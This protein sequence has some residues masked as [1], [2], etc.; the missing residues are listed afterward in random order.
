MATATLKTLNRYTIAGHTF[1][2]GVAKT[3]P[4]DLA[5]RLSEHP[6][7]SERLAIKISPAEHAENYGKEPE[8]PA[9]DSAPKVLTDA[10]KLD[11]IKA[12]VSELDVDNPD[13]FTKS[14]LP[15]ARALTSVLGWQVTSAMRDK[16]MGVGGVS[17]A[18]PKPNVA[19]GKITIVRKGSGDA[20]G[21]LLDSGAGASTEDPTVVG[22]VDV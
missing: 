9:E 6:L 3:I 10:E 18:D 8:A 14:G 17:A 12:A 1:E 19:V 13:H 4:Y 22:A 21:D 2:R 20:E 5:M 15:D 16:A 7:A 11:A